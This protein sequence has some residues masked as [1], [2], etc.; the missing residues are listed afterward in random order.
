MLRRTAVVTLTGVTCGLVLPVPALAQAWL[1]LKREATVSATFQRVAA[2]G[3]FLEDGSK[4]PGYR[5]RASN[6]VVEASYGIADRLA[7]ALTVPFVNV[8]YLGPDEPLNLP[9]NV[10]D[11]GRYHGTVTDLRLEVRYNPLQRPLA[12][13]PF[14]AAVIPSHSYPTLGEA[15]PGRDFQ[16]YHLGAY[17]GRLLDPVLP[18]AF[19]HGSFAYAFVRQ[20][21]DIP[22]D[23]SGLSLET[24]YFVTPS[25][26]I[27]VFWRRH[28]THGGLSFNEL[29][30]APPEVFVNLDRVV[31]V[32]YQH[33]GVAASFPLGGSLSAHANYVWFVDGVDAHYGSGFSVG[34]SWRFRPSTGIG[35]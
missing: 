28:W 9:D 33:V 31:R 21:L 7:I 6:A 18:R 34:L 35:G 4:L 12:F 17:A 10:L 1:P 30:E 32:G 15:A 25:V 24:G 19:V 3:H 16:E 23:Y 5:T 13:T 11:D 8:K 26:S 20:D 27:G 22:L 14:A 29:F 2:D